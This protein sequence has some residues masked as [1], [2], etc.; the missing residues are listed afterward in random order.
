MLEDESGRIT[1]D[2]KLVG[3]EYFPCFTGV[4]VALI[5]AES[6]SGEFLVKE[7]CLADFPNP[8]SWSLQASPD[9]LLSNPDDTDPSFLAFLSA[10]NVGAADEETALKFSMALEA[11]VHQVRIFRM[12][13]LWINCILRNIFKLNICLLSVIYW[14]NTVP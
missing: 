11:I 3:R 14:P 7:Y 5:G 4:V 8:V 1:L 9:S 13:E 10:P 12:I 6:A 2:L